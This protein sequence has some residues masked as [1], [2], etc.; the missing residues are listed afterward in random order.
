MKV[1]RNITKKKGGGKRLV[2]K[3]KLCGWDKRGKR[4]RLGKVANEREDKIGEK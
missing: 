3:I 4:G 2:N 1:G